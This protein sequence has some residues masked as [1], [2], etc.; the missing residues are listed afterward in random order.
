MFG[1]DEQIVHYPK[2]F[3]GMYFQ[4]KEMIEIINQDRSNDQNVQVQYSVINF[5]KMIKK[6]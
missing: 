2:S 3:S 5:D 1:S 6:I 4:L